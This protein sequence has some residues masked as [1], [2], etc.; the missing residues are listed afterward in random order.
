MTQCVCPVHVRSLRH[1]PPLRSHSS[2]SRRTSRRAASSTPSSAPSP[3]SRTSTT[4]QTG[5]PS[6]REASSFF[7]RRPRTSCRRTTWASRRRR[8][9]RRPRS[10]AARRSSARATR[11]P[12]LTSPQ[13]SRPSRACPQRAASR[14][15]CAC[16]RSSSPTCTTCAFTS[17]A[18]TCVCW[19]GAWGLGVRCSLGRLF[20]RPPPSLNSAGLARRHRRLQPRRRVRGL[21]GH[22]RA[23]V[24]PPPRA[25]RQRREH[26]PRHG[27][28]LSRMRRREFR[29]D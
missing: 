2:R 17:R 14:C 6:R 19:G 11:E 10:G 15:P 1:P 18:A 7:P 8:C 3:S 13:R 22:G 12:S 9:S 5:T 20:T 24:V 27:V 4:R 26:R 16:A 25:L 28:S 21:Q 23:G 29:F